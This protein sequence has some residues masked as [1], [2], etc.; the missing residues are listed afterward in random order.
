MRNIFG[1]GMGIDLNSPICAHTMREAILLRVAIATSI[2]GLLGLLILADNSK[3][4]DYTPN[5]AQL[6]RE[7]KLTGRV[8]SVVEKERVAFLKLI[9]PAEVSVVLFKP[10]ELSIEE[11]QSIE[12]VGIVENNYKGKANIIAYRVSSVG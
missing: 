3:P 8:V 10:K 12:V 4:S 6:D 2:M 5:L 11:N 9:Y 1:I 7:V